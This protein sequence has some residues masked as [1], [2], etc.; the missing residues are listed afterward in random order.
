MSEIV[1]QMQ[2]RWADA[3]A[4]ADAKALAAL[5][6]DDALFFGSMPDLYLGAS[7]VRRYFET[8]P[9]GYENAAFAD[10][11]AVEIGAA[12]IVAAGFV[13]FTGE[14]NRER[15]SFLYRMSWTLVRTG[16]DW[17]I[18]SHHAS[19]KNWSSSSANPT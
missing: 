11:Q 12:L 14:R 1:A 7:G 3:F 19:P 10:T 17:R 4:R 5:Y 2:R 18:A 8:L 13:T 16:G 15:F 9:K 6:M